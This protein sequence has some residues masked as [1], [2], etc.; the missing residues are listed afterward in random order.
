[1]IVDALRIPFN[2]AC[3]VGTEQSNVAEA[4]RGGHISGD[5]PF[6]QR[7]EA[8]L[9]ERLGVARGLLTP[10]CTHALELAA[11]LT[12]VG[13]GDEV[14]LPSFTFVSTANAFV[15]HGATPVFAD[16][17]PDT[18]NLDPSSV[19][20]IAGPRTKVI[21]PV[22]YGGVGCEMGEL[23]ALAAG[24]GAEIVEDN[25]HGLLGAHGGKPLGTFGRLATLSFH[26]TKNF[27]C[28]EGGAL[29]VNDPA[30]V[31][32]AEIVRQK[33]TNR[34]QFLKGQVDKYTWVDIGSSHVMSDLL[35]AVLWSQF[36]VADT[37]QARRR[38][39]WNRYYTE[40]KDWAAVTGSTL[41]G[42][43]DD[44]EQ[45]YHLFYVLLPSQSERDALIRHLRARGILAVFHYVPLHTSPMGLRFGGKP[46]QCPVTEDVSARLIRLPFFNDLSVDDQSR[47]IEAVHDFGRP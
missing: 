35:A 8:W 37:I 22:H 25:A 36:E 26:E 39:I 43:P 5:G 18:L 17:R 34:A 44:A 20:A 30:L 2:R 29:L 1:V 6:T 9:E 15:L 13:R 7:C 21:V 24:L 14:I 16:I 11:I 32:R 28:G 45:A 42:V 23:G 19:A 12:G 33:G 38:A 46:G 31:E 27:T 40:L 3:F 4:V 41:P 10:S 47:V